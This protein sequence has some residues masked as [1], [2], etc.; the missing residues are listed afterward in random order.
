MLRELG[1]TYVNSLKVL[2]SRER[3]DLVDLRRMASVYILATSEIP[4]LQ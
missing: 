1:P 3:R 4:V 2:A